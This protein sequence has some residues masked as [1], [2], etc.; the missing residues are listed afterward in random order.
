[1]GF[2]I[3]TNDSQPSANSFLGDMDEVALYD[4]ALSQERV[5]LHYGLG[6]YGTNVAP[7]IIQEPLAQDV[8][9]GCPAVL[10]AIAYAEPAPNFQWYKDGAPVPGAT[11]SSF[12]FDSANYGDNGLYSVAVTN[13]LGTINTQPVRVSVWPPLQFCNLTN[14]L[15]LHLKFDG[16]YL[17]SSG[18]SNNSTPVGNPFFVSARIGSGALHYQTDTTAGKYDYVTLGIPSDLQFNSNVAFSG[19]VLGEIHRHSG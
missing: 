14:D 12:A 15:V 9:V 11:R 13:G 7:V 16:N 5:A 17:D 1:M 2:G 6:K 3:S 4:H 10:G 19:L 8:G 18:R